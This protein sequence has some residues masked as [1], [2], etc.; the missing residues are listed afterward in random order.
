[1]QII[2]YLSDI[3]QFFLTLEFFEPDICM[4]NPTAPVGIH[5]G[6]RLHLLEYI[7]FLGV[8]DFLYSLG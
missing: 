2:L 4:E 5:R 7:T 1:M 6:E 3:I 8:N